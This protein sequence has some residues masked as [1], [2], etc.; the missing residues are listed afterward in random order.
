MAS[1]LQLRAKY[2]PICEH[3]RYCKSCLKADLTRVVTLKPPARK[4]SR[5]RTQQDYANLNSGLQSDP[6]RWMK[7]LEGRNIKDDT[8]KRMKGCDVTMEWLHGDEGAMREPIIVPDPEGLGIRMP[9][10]DFSVTNVA[11]MVGE[12]TSVEVI[13]MALTLCY[14]IGF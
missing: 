7:I 5:K 3:F 6:A 12:D 1:T 9:Q 4:S 10:K 8:F 11:E 14:Y 2:L 13:G